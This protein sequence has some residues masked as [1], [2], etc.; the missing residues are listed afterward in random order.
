MAGMLPPR[1]WLSMLYAQGGQVTDPTPEPAPGGV[2]A[3]FTITAEAE[4]TRP[5]STEG[6]SA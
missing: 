2:L 4:V 5:G 1:R 6:E 3:G